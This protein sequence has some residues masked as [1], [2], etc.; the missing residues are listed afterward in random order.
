MSFAADRQTLDDLSLFPKDQRQSVLSLFGKTQTIGGQEVLALLFSKPLD[1]RAEIKDRLAV[2]RYL[3]QHRAVF[4]SDR[5]TCDFAEFYL[6]GQNTRKSFPILTGLINQLIY[7]LNSNNDYYISKQGVASVLLLLENLLIF[8]NQ[9]TVSAPKI[10]WD[11]RAAILIAFTESEWDLVKQWIAKPKLTAADIARA[12]H[13]F[14]NKA[15]SELKGLLDI[16]YHLDAFQTISV[17]SAASGFT[18]PDLEED[19]GPG[20][21]LKGLFHPFINNPVDNDIEF[22]TDQNVCFVTGTNMAGKSTLLKALGISVYLSQ[23]GFPVP[24]SYMKTSFFEGLMSTINLPDDIDQGQSHFY[25]E[26][27]R[28]KQVAEQVSRSK[29][30][31]V[32]FDELFRGTNVKDAYDASLAIISAFANV[33][34]SLFVV[35]THIVEVAHQLS[36]IS[37][38]DFRYMETIFDN[39]HPVNSYKLRS[40]ITEE[41][42]GMWIVKNE[43]ILELIQGRS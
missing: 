25:R 22:R 39:D 37:N 33:R 4:K 26:V 12:N 15:Y 6:K 3:Q 8:T 16:A 27:L 36:A 10:F 42:L 40:G 20:L 21:I 32:I 34:S 41:R 2:F 9:L 30:M 13:L 24:A 29:N 1:S 35:S 38:I 14:R 23:L 31:F 43:K 19:G 28:V 11:Q 7:A 18:V 5:N 17:N